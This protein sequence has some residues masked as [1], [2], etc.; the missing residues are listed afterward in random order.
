MI[1]RII[2]WGQTFCTWGRFHCSNSPARF[3]INVLYG[4]H[5]YRYFRKISSSVPN[6]AISNAK[7]KFDSAD[8]WQ[9]NGHSQVSGRLDAERVSLVLS[10]GLT[11]EG[12]LDK[13]LSS[14]TVVNGSGYW[15]QI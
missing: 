6:F 15:G 10:N 14:S 9:F 5:L 12:V 2:S 7:V 13:P 3:R 1:Q 11:L 8:H 4:G